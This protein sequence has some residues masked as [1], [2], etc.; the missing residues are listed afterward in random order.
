MKRIPMKM[1]TASCSA[2]MLL[3]AFPGSL[4][5]QS[6]AKDTTLNRTVIVEQQ[7]NP[8][9][10]DAQKVNVL[11][12][13]RE[14]TTTPNEVEYDQNALPASVLPGT[15]M[16]AYAGEEKQHT[17]KQGYAR[18]G[19]GNKGNLDVEGNYLFALTPQERLNLS[20][21]MQG[22]NGHSYRPEG[23]KWDSRYYR[24]KAGVDYFSQYDKVNLNLG[25]TFGLSN[26]NYLV[27]SLDRQ[28]FTSGDFHAGVTSIDESLPIQ[29]RLET[30]LMLYSR[31]YDFVDDGSVNETRIRTKGDFTGEV[32]DDQKI[33]VAFELNN[34]FYSNKGYD[35]Y[36]TLLLNPYYEW[37]EEEVWKL[38]AG[39]NTD[40][41]FGFGKKFRVSPDVTAEYILSEGYVL[42]AHATG[43]RK[44]ND[45]RRLEEL[46]PYGELQHWLGVVDQKYDSYEQLNA[47]LGFKMSP[48]PGFWLNIY[49]GYQN[50]KDD[51]FDL[52]GATATYFSQEK[53]TN[54]FTGIQASY[55]YKDLFNITSRFQ[56]HNWDADNELT[57]RFKPKNRLDMQLGVRPMPDLSL[58]L[59]Y[60]YVKREEIKQGG[61]SYREKEI[62]NLSV[63]AT[64]EVFQSI[65]I[66]ARLSNLFNKKYAYYVQ[67][68]MPGF[69]YVGGLMFRF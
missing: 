66:Y 42:Y 3:A 55:T 51:L 56:Y 19:L 17:A 8:D 60:E 25:G 24:T 43:G 64:Y 44:L 48:A 13:M 50:I 38:H 20:L 7:Y 69:N 4:S 61:F 63:G 34:L 1:W 26:F 41:A 47:A 54:F 10:M 36:T 37:Q 65:Y 58:N 6:H 12:E 68:P 28:R 21:G 22:M 59:S 11:P 5:A 39:V 67:S 46:N 57:L 18:L 40:L 35:N 23:G 49:G 52:E 30:N 53:T 31:A 16:A 45:F 33:G 15:A 62:N 2:V 27:S 14:F 32:T 29:F 9:I